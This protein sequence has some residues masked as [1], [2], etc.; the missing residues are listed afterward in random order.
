M[1]QVDVAD[2]EGGSR[3]DGME[4]VVLMSRDK[5]KGVRILTKACAQACRLM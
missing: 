2:E 5:D 3:D 1:E 4:M